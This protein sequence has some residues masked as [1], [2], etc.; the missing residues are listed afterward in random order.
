[1]EF[2]DPKR[3]DLGRVMD[4]IGTATQARGLTPEI[5]DAILR[6]K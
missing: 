1:L 6:D 2:T 4:D 3:P 5:L